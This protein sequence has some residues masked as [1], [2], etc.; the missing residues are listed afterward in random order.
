M[1]KAAAC[2]VTQANQHIDYSLFGKQTCYI[3]IFKI[4][5]S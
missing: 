4:Q 2:A 3:Q 1:F 5:G